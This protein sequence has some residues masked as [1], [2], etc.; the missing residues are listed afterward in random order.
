MKPTRCAELAGR[1]LLSL[2][3]IGRMLV[4]V[5]PS[6]AADQLATYFHYS[7]E[8]LAPLHSLSTTSEMSL[9]ELDRVD[10]VTFELMSKHNVDADQAAKILAY[11][12]VAQRDSGALSARVRGKFAGSVGPV[13]SMVLCDFF[14]VDCPLVSKRL[15]ADPY[16]QALAGVIHAKIKARIDEENQQ[17]KSIEPA[18]GD[19]YWTGTLPYGGIACPTWKPWAIESASQFRAPALP[20]LD[21]TSPEWQHQLQAVRQAVSGITDEQRAKGIFY[22]GGP[23]T[24]TWIGVWVDQ[25]TELFKQYHTPLGDAFLI[26]SL[27]GMALVDAV[28]TVFDTKY[29]YATKRPNQVDPSII[30]IMPTP[31]F[32]AYT[33]GHSCL[34]GAASAVLAHFFPSEQDRL[35]ALNKEIENSRVWIGVHYPIDGDVGTPQG[36][37][38]GAWVIYRLMSREVEL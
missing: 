26:R 8:D 25:A 19:Q 37:R 6:Q 34:S 36:R 29:A 22:A 30:T 31:N 12:T 3:L 1:S 27:L 38:V 33:A 7:T 28:I 18:V 13:S 20:A 10:E 17:V 2:M 16:S 35:F 11:L 32:P 14:P 21:Y 5:P 15:D 4:N 9:R 23:G 24:R